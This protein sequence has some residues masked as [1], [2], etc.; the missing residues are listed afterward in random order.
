MKEDSGMSIQEIMELILHKIWLVILGMIIGGVIAYVISTYVV[1]PT[2]KANVSMYVNNNNQED[3][4]LNLNDLS[5]SQQLVT[6]YIEIL[7]SDAVLNKI[8]DKLD[9]SYSTSELR[10]MISATAINGTEIFNL[11]VTSSNPEEAADIANML[12]KV[13]PEEIVR[14]VRAGSVE[15]IDSAKT[16]YDPV[17]PNI[18][19]NIIIGTLGMGIVTIMIIILRKLLDTTV[20]SISDLEKRYNIPVLGSVPEIRK[21]KQ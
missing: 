15:V 3:T 21:I 10:K 12:A 8:I 4:S 1:T 14:V 20:R 17:T 19:L 11:E 13:A 6:T 7:K 9:L 18:Q 5:V 16:N 2:Y